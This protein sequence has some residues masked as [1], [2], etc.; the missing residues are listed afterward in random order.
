MKNIISYILKKYEPNTIILY[1]SYA[2]GSNN[3]N[4]DFDAL[5]ITDKEC[6][7]HDGSIVDGIVLDVFVY[8]TSKFNSEIN[9]E[10]YIQIFDGNI[11]LDKINL[12][13]W[14]KDKVN[15]YIK[16][17]P[18]KSDE[19]NLMQVEWCEKMFARIE[20]NDAEG[21]YRWHW[22][23]VDSLEIYFDLCGLRYIGPKK[24]L[25]ILFE[26]EPESAI[27]YENALSSFKK[28][29]LK[30]WVIELRKKYNNSIK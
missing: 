7:M 26:E 17:I 23:L 6:P 24:S 25:S 16:S 30:E 5:V 21:Y 27:I 3:V 13:I 14:L 9:C 12:G 2:N 22:L 18:M 19:E 20:R 1:G 4:S 15:A 10:D 28:D 8:H 29:S 11:I